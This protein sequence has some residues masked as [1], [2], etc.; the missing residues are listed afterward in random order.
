[1][2]EPN[3]VVHPTDFSDTAH[4]AFRYALHLAKESDASLH[5]LHVIASLGVDPIRG[6]FESGVD[7]E[8]FFYEM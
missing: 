3:V 2:F 1:M 4:G 7:E 6:A 8:A 5:L